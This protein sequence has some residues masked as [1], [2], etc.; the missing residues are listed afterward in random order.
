MAKKP[1][2]LVPGSGMLAAAGISSWMSKLSYRGLYYDQSVDPLY[3][4]DYSRIYVFWHEYILLPLYLRGHCN[5]TMLLSKHRDADILARVALHL[6][7]QCVRGSTYGG[8]A[9]ALRELTRLGRR[10]HLTITPDGPRGPRRRLAQGPV[11]LASRTQM[12]LVPLGFGVDRPWRVR[13]WDRFAIPRPFSRARA[14]VGPEIYI[15]SNADRNCLERHRLQ[16]ERLLNALT[17]DA[18]RWAESG[19]RREGSVA[20]RRQGQEARRT[21]TPSVSHPPAMSIRRLAVGVPH[22]PSPIERRLAA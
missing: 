6:G 5:L 16:V 13:S 4:A 19:A 11:F 7:F 2:W 21:T 9:A 12:P 18:E 14:V 10:K 20:A 3:P 22:G 1:E 15:P 17:T 8:A